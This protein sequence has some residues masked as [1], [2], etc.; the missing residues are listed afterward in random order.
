MTQDELHS[1]AGTRDFLAKMLFVVDGHDLEG[2]HAPRGID[3]DDVAFALAD[4]R[5][6][7]G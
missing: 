7:N 1:P 2:F 5:P 4:E 3:V 6:G